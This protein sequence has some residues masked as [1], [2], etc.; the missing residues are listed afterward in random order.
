MPGACYDDTVTQ[1]TVPNNTKQRLH[2]YILYSL[3][4]DYNMYGEKK[5]RTLLIRCR[6]LAQGDLSG[7]CQGM[8][9]AFNTFSTVKYVLEGH[10]RGTN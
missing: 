3:R 4:C 5:P 1:P 2:P 6:P 8:F 7:V 10:D 9:G